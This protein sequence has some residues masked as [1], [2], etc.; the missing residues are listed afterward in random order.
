MTHTTAYDAARALSL[1]AIAAAS[2]GDPDTVVKVMAF[3]HLYDV[4]IQP[5]GN[6]DQQFSHMDNERV[7][8]RLSLHIEEFKELLFKG[9]GINCTMIFFIGDDDLDRGDWRTGDIKAALDNAASRGIPRNGKEVMDALG[10][11]NYVDTGMSIEMGYDPRPVMAEIHAGNM[12]KLGADGKPIINGVTPGYRAD[13]NLSGHEQAEIA[14]PGFDP[15][16]R[17]GKVLKGPNY[18]EPNIAASLGW[19]DN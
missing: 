18:V 15:T 1:P 5:F 6:A 8:L 16:A 19:D 11:I 3:H 10:D 12:T 4:P 14:E 9:F 13:P 7:A 2:V 17:F